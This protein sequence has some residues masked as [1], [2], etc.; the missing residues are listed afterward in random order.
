M[1]IKSKIKNKSSPNINIEQKE[2]WIEFNGKIIEDLYAHI[3]GCI[4]SHKNER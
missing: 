2:N 1:C 4:S 3:L